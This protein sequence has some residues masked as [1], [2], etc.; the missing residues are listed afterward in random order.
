MLVELPTRRRDVHL[1]PVRERDRP[2]LV[3]PV[4]RAPASRLI[5][6]ADQL[7][8]VPLDGDVEIEVPHP[9]QDV[10]NRPAHQVG[11]HP[12][13]LRPGADAVQ[14][15]ED[16]RG[17][18]GLHQRG[19]PLHPEEARP[20]IRLPRGL[21]VSIE[22]A[23]EV[24]PCQDAHQPAALEHRKPL[25]AVGRHQ[26]MRLVDRGL[27]GYPDDALRHEVA[28]ARAVEAVQ[29]RL[30]QVLARHHAR[31][32]AVLQGDGQ[33]LVAE[34]DHRPVRLVHHGVGGDRQDGGGHDA[35][36]VEHPGNAPMQVLLQL[37][38]QLLRVPVQDRCRARLDVAAA[39]V[40]RQE[41]LD[42]QHP[43]GAADDQ[44]DLAP[45]AAHR[46]QG[47]VGL[48][49]VPQTVHEEGKPLHVLLRL[50]PGGQH[51]G[52]VDVALPGVLRQDVQQVPLRSRHGDLRPRQDPGQ[53]RPHLPKTGHRQDVPCGCGLVGQ[54]SR[55]VVDPEGEERRLLGRYG[56]ALPDE[57]LHE[58][59]HRRPYGSPL[60]R[61]GRDVVHGGRV[62]V[63]D[64]HAHVMPSGEGREGADA[65]PRPRVH[66][67]HQGHL[68]HGD[69]LGL[70][71]LPLVPVVRH[72]VPHLAPHGAGGADHRIRVELPDGDH[73]RQGIE[74]GVQVT[75][76]Q[77]HR[78]DAPFNFSITARS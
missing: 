24:G 38:Q 65:A 3:T 31:D 57:L 69:L 62:V 15:V 2:R 32:L 34:A 33:S 66:D 49:V 46:R 14:Q 48:A 76:D 45:S 77:L 75:G 18:R 4:H 55:I 16:A 70:Q 29:M 42:V 78:R 35:R 11:L 52:P 64:M 23:D 43:R 1:Q 39:A 5:P 74:I 59:R 37:R 71:K 54:G 7:L 6:A 19:D 30:V 61:L 13:R 58:H 40:G 67:N 56:L 25:E 72:E 68:F 12:H 22:G 50:R 17:K 27:R 53:V 9:H 36:H 60:H 10:P 20:R 73:A 8:G 47:D 28:D 26:P 21:K 63:V 44:A 51:L 41:L